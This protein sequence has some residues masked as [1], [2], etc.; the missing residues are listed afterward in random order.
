[1]QFLMLKMKNN[2][3]KTIQC[4]I[5]DLRIGEKIHEVLVSKEEVKRLGNSD[6]GTFYV[7]R[8]SLPKNHSDCA[9][10]GNREYSSKDC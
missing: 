10:F 4:L 9:Q 5:Q 3:E 6:C 8:P 7:L 2:R 1:M